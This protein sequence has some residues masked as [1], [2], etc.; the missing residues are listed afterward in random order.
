MQYYE[1]I[2]LVKERGNFTS[3]VDAETAV[4]ATLYTLGEHLGIGQAA[5]LAR[6]LPHE[7]WDYIL[8]RENAESFGLDEFIERIGRKEGIAPE[9]AVNHARAVLSVFAEAVSPDELEDT[10]AQLPLD[11]QDFIRS[12]RATAGRVAL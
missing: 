12:A 9:V 8:R 1:F 11:I 10:I 4:R 3:K 7:V 2:G 5:D 6:E